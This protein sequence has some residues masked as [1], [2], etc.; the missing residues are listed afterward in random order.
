[1]KVKWHLEEAVMLVD[2]YRRVEELDAN[3]RQQEIEKLSFLLNKRAK[4]LQ[5]PIDDKFRNV[6]GIIMQLE[7]IRY[8]ETKGTEGLSA[9]SK[10]AQEA[11]QLNSEMPEVFKRIVQEFKEKYEI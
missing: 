6:N 10:V 9:F 3:T 1:M 2:L 5:I 8:I 7:N 11:Y 4:I